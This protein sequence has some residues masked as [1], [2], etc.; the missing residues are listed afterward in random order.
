MGKKDLAVKAKDELI[1]ELEGLRRSAKEKPAPPST[2]A[3]DLQAEMKKAVDAAEAT[4]QLEAKRA[5][6]RLKDE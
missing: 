6:Q 1:T 3:A 4:N 5:S 2:P